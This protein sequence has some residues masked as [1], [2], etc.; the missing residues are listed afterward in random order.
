MSIAQ[1]RLKN[2]LQ[3]C[4]A[5]NKQ[6]LESLRIRITSEKDKELKD[7]VDKIQKMFKKELYHLW[8]E[9]EKMK[10]E[11]LKNQLLL[12][13][14]IKIMQQQEMDLYDDF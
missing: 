2:Q 9:R 7:K 4:T 12:K 5:Q 6:A 11:H 14:M 8:N 10:T 3:Q 13:K 1:T